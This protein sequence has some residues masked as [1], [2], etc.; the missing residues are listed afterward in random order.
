MA[1]VP[2]PFKINVS[3]ETLSWITERVKTARIIPDISHPPGKEWADGIP[4]ST[5]QGLVDYWRNSYDWRKVEERI[6]LTFNMF[7]VELEE[8]GENIELHYVHHR[9]MREGAVPLLF[10]HGWPGN[11]LEVRMSFAA[12]LF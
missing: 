4:S 9:S 10:A 11:F 5:M 7:T 6:N 12:S 1:S 8:A 3:P 2:K